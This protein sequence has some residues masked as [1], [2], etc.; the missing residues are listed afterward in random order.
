MI[1]GVTANPPSITAIN[2]RTQAIRRLKPLLSLCFS[3]DLLTNGRFINKN[4]QFYAGTLDNTRKCAYVCFVKQ[5][6]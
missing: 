2:S 3:I 6:V 5:I 4:D 1:L